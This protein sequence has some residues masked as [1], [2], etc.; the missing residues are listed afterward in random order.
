MNSK[1]IYTGLNIQFP[2]SRLILSGKKTVETRTYS[3]PKKYIGVDMLMVETPGKTGK[4]KSR[5]VAIIKFEKCF[6]YKNS[7]EFY[8]DF[9]QHCVTPSSIWGW[10]D[11]KPKW[12]WIISKV[13]KLDSPK[14]VKRRLGIIFSNGLE[15]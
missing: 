9:E 14:V 11:R 13:K 1:K 7:E 12:G 2:I 8:K 3:I 5:I 6:A 15:L 4:F 10:S